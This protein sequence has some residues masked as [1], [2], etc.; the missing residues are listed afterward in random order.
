MDKNLNEYSHLRHDIH[1]I[2]HTCLV[3]VGGTYGGRGVHIWDQHQT[4]TSY[5]FKLLVAELGFNRQLYL[6]HDLQYI[7]Q[8]LVIYM[9]ADT[10]CLGYAKMHPDVLKT[11]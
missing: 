2:C 11:G 4:L 6:L 9:M 10:V 5:P 8:R 1:R 7:I 3:D